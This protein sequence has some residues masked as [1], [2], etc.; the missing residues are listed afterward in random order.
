MIDFI[1]QNIFLSLN[2]CFQPKVLQLYFFVLQMLVFFMLHVEKRVTSLFHLFRTFH[3][4]SP[5]PS[6][7]SLFFIT[8]LY[9]HQP[10][11]YFP[12]PQSIFQT[13]SYYPPSLLSYIYIF[14]C[15]K[16]KPFQPLSQLLIITFL[17]I[18]QLHISILSSFITLKI[19]SPNP[20]KIFIHSPLKLLFTS[21]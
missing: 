3:E 16:F 17:S 12:K 11:L 8:P 2:Q 1:R 21:I 4:F 6:S 19:N 7:H 9:H 18:S 13:L 20:I 10:L 15:F 14:L 5:F